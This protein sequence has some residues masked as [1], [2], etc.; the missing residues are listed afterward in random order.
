MAF[1]LGWYAEDKSGLRLLRTFEA[2]AKGSGA[3]LIK[4]SCNGGTAQRILERCGYA[5]AEL[6]MCKAVS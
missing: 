4:L 3:T 6:Q 1:E 2:W 5:V